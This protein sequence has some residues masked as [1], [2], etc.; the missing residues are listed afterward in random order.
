[1]DIQSTS[2]WNACFA[3]FYI[4]L[5]YKEFVLARK[6]FHMKIR[7]AS[8]KCVYSV[9]F[10]VHTDKHILRWLCYKFEVNIISVDGFM[11][12]VSAFA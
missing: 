9:M 8:K 5:L 4:S 1:M 2:K 11:A 7:Q 3:M 6:D 12:T 10:S